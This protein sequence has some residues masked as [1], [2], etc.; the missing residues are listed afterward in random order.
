VNVLPPSEARLLG[1]L[2][3]GFGDPTRRLLYSLVTD[4][5]DG[6]TA[7]EAGHLACVHRT[8]A[9]AHLE[10]LVQIGL[11]SVSSRRG[12]GGGRPSKVYRAPEHPLSVA[13]PPRRYEHLAG[14][15]LRAL[16]QAVD[17]AAAA[18]AAEGVGW[19]YGREVAVGHPPS[20]GDAAAGPGGQRLSP[21]A[22]QTWLDDNGYRATVGAGDSLTIEV[23]NCVFRELAVASP[24]VVCS[25]DQ[26]LIRG[27]LGAPPES[28]EVV[29]RVVDG[30]AI[31]R[32][33]LTF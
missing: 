18:A 7:A 28:L 30:D 22:V 13:V 2:G 24:V 25:L 15:L 19:A 26:A 11:L 4:A 5:T 21:S 12:P 23:A 33:R 1:R 31:C 9:R 3:D 10:R 32:F 8:V 27:L 17:E 16:S 20:D 6:L 29:S 14:L